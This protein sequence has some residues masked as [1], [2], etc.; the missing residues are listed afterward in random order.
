[1]I[2]YYENIDNEETSA[3]LETFL[4]NSSWKWGYKSVNDLT[5]RS[6][7]HWTII[8]GGKTNPKDQNFDCEHELTGIVKTVWNNVKEKYLQEDDR[9]VRCYANAISTGIDQRLHVDDTLPG[10]KTLIVY[11]N[12]TWTV[13]YAGETIIWDREKRQIIGSYLPKFNSCLLISGNCWHGVRPVSSYC[14][15][16]RMS[17]MFK[18]RP[19]QSFLYT[20]TTRS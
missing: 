15:T 20:H 6:I 11:V 1:M 9:L 7:P 13:D 17:I 12:K 10:A 5:T 18:T 4:L 8:F 3:E 14:D 2:E 16:I 19:V